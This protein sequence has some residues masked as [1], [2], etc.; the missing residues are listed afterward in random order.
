MCDTGHTSVGRTGS[1]HPSVAARP[2][3]AVVRWY[4]LAREGRPSPCRFVPSCS[5]YAAEAL[6]CHGALKGSWLGLR[7]LSRCHPWGSSG[8]DPVP[9]RKGSTWNNSPAGPSGALPPTPPSAHDH[10]ESPDQRVC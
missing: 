9:Q 6:E 1:G 5:T 8:Y 7:R 10:H 4:Q 2:L 3:L